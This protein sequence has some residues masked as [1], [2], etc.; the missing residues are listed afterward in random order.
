MNTERNTTVNFSVLARQLTPTV[1]RRPVWNALMGALM[2]PFRKLNADYAAFRAAKRMRMTHNGQVRLLERI[3][4]TLMVGGYNPAEPVIHIGE[5]LPAEEFLIAPDG[6]W[7]L[8]TGIYY[9]RRGKD[10]W[11]YYNRAEAPEQ[12]SVLYDGGSR[13]GSLGFEVHLAPALSSLAP[14]NAQRDMYLN[15][16]GEAALRDIIDTYKLAGKQYSLIQD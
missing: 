7:S 12:F 5:S 16:G 6:G 11:D 8:Q 14:R 3:A 15:N 10:H 1:L 13:V 9:D 4:N 2:A